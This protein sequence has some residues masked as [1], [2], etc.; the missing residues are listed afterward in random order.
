MHQIPQTGSRTDAG[1]WHNWLTWQ[2]G[3]EKFAVTREALNNSCC[4]YSLKQFPALFKLYLQE[5][6]GGVVHA[7]DQAAHAHHVVHVGEADQAHSG[8]VMHKH[9]E[10]VLK[11]R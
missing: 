6:V 4:S 8:Q 2:P 3:K 11:T 5:E 7:Q 10:E 1:I 9:D